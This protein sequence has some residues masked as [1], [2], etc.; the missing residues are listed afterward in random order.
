MLVPLLRPHE[1]HAPPALL[2][3]PALE[4]LGVLGL[5]A[6]Q[7]LLGKR[8]RRV[9]VLLE[10]GAEDLGVALVPVG[11]I[12]RLA[13]EQPGAA[14]LEHDAA[15]VG[16]VAAHGH[17]VPIHPLPHDRAQA[18]GD[19]L[20]GLDLVAHSRRALELEPLA[21]LLHPLPQA[22]H[23]LVGAP[24]QEEAHPV[25]H[26]EVLAARLQPDAGRPAHLDVV[27]EARPVDAVER[28]GC[29]GAGGK[30]SLQ[31][32]EGAAHGADVGVRAEVLAAVVHEGARR[33]DAWEGVGGDAD[34]GELLVVA[35]P[36]VVA[37]PV[38]L[39]EVALEDES[40]D[41]GGGH[42]VVEV[43]DPGHER[44]GLRGQL[45]SGAEI[46]A[47]PIRERL[48]LTDVDHL[49]AGVLEQVHPRLGRQRSQLLD[50]LRS[51]LRQ[52]GLLHCTPRAPRTPLPGRV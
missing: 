1:P 10:E 29:A 52:A 26:F 35:Q 5:L 51:A 12:E 37:R 25:H 16:T 49:A 44:L 46:G 38:L 30:H 33:N 18:V 31:E 34:V 39:D 43:L 8:G 6:R 41:L 24:A 11:E 17:G 19:P 7:D 15:G 45:G 47:D 13:R 4:E 23:Q 21:V 48:R 50:E 22:R 42:H 14:D 32:R 27:V 36:D 40:L 2:R 3:E 20:D 9:V 28:L